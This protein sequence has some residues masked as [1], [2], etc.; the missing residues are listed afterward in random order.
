[1]LLYGF[2][3]DGG[4]N[5]FVARTLPEICSEHEAHSQ[6]WRHDCFCK[7]RLVGDRTLTGEWLIF[8]PNALFFG[9]FF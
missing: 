2:S 4:L 6:F 9:A 8:K 7:I 5:S 3:C 1:M